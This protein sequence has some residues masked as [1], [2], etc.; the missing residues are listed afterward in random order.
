MPP[1][2]HLALALLLPA[3]ACDA[4]PTSRQAVATTPAATTPPP[5]SPT[6]S[7]PPSASSATSEASP[8][9][10]PAPAPGARPADAQLE[11]LAKAGNSF[12]FAL[13]GK[14]RERPGD[15]AVSPFSASTALSM[16]WLGARGETAAQMKKVLA[17]DG[18]PEEA[19]DVSARYA[20][21]LGGPL[22]FRSAN[23]IFVERSFPLEKAFV[24]ATGRIFGAPAEVSDFKGSPDAAR[25]RINGWVSG[26]TR[27]RIKDLIPPGGLPPAANLALV[28][29]VYFLGD[30]A[31]PFKAEDTQPW[32]FH[33]SKTAEH[34]VPM[35][36]LS[37]EARYGETDDVKLL[38]LPYAGGSLEMAFVLPKSVDGLDA[39]ERRL[40]AA[41]FDG[42]VTG[43]KTT[44]VGVKLPKFTI[45]PRESL[46]LGD[47]LVALGMPLAF[48]RTKADF[49]GIAVAKT[50][51]DRISISRVFHKAFVKV[52]EKGTEAAAA[53]AVVM[54]PAGAPPGPA[55]R[56]KEFHADH[57]FLFFLRDAKSGQ[58]LFAG[59]VADPKAS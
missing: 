5:P 23:R 1:L 15:L 10:E 39:V 56:A 17:Y 3:V 46:A 27:G 21:S 6:T 42:W 40:S 26:E 36:Q 43:M 54:A 8:A 9:P 24:E 55:R 14:L 18:P 57:P 53:T 51:A 13:Y 31:T 37:L 30:W 32:A 50:P 34:Q 49:S 48:D 59:R 44:S 28:N 19:G 52:D 22:T 12:A 58:I 41:T 16:T 45:D 4:K 25:D 7:A 29:A 11:K 33:T 38:S 20:R 2:R 35:M 47:A